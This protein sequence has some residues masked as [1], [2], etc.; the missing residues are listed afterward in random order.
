MATPPKLDVEIVTGER[1]VYQAED[2]DMVLA[3]GADGELGILPRHAALFSLLSAGEMIVR[4]GTEEQ[5]LVVFGGFIQVRNNHVL[6]LADAAEHIE[7]IDVERAE[8]ARRSA[9]EQ[10]QGGGGGA[11]VE[12]TLMSLRRSQIRIQAAGRRGRRR[13]RDSRT[14]AES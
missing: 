3:P 10:L 7:E 2:V 4:K 13:R 1:V 14:S 12:Q 5:P 9:E 8:A 6:V 11:D